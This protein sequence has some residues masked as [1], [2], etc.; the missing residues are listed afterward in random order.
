MDKASYQVDGYAFVSRTEYERALKEKETV[1]YLLASTDVTDTKALLKLYN[2]SIGK[3]SFRTVVGLAYMGE[4][5]RNIVESGV[6]SEE[7]LAP[8]PVKTVSRTG[9]HPAGVDK[10]TLSVE[11]LKAQVERY[12]EACE[13]AKAGRLI[14][15]LTIFILTV[16]IVAILFITYK[17]QYSVF[18]YFTN[19]KE[20]MRNEVIDEY[21]EWQNTL[22]EKEQEL[23]ERE[24]ALQT[25]K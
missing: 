9:Q 13:T 12:K 22:E 20:T 11:N 7:S 15:N 16:V 3:E 24:Q 21:E 14:K 5:R 23:E 25:E 19:Y 1:S 8:I 17:S 18:T 6:V 2:R 10:E 4:L